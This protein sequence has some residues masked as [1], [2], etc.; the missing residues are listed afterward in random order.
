MAKSATITTLAS[1]AG[2]APAPLDI[3]RRLAQHLRALADLSGYLGDPGNSN[4]IVIKT[5][6]HEPGCSTQ[7]QASLEN[8]AVQPER[9]R[10]SLAATEVMNQAFASFEAVA[11]DNVQAAC[12]LPDGRD[13]VVRTLSVSE[14]P[15]SAV[16]PVAG[17]LP[18]RTPD[19]VQIAIASLLQAG[20]ELAAFFVDSEDGLTVCIRSVLKQTASIPLGEAA[21]K[22]ALGTL[23]RALIQFNATLPLESDEILVF[24]LAT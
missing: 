23:Q 18:R 4:R 2:Q 15:R 24:E 19:Q 7:P 17:N 14:L 16:E 6:W 9:L 22:D 11:Y 10:R 12:V 20:A 8:V 13:D 1:Y 21:P 5:F 3:Q